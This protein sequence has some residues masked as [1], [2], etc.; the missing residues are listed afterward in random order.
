MPLPSHAFTIHGGCNCR[1]IR[2][3]VN[4][5]PFSERT[6]HPASGKDELRYPFSAIC[7]CN[8]CRRATGALITYGYCCA[9]SS[10]SFCLASASTSNSNHETWTPAA[11]LFPPSTQ[12]R[13]DTYLQFYASSEDRTRCFCARCGTMIGY[14]VHPMPE[15]WPE[16]LDLWTG[17]VDREDLEREWLVPGRHVQLDF[18]IPWVGKM[19]VEG[20]DGLGGLPKHKRGTGHDLDVV[21]TAK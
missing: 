18:E 2:Y 4:V 11:A 21:S 3:E 1:A 8:D 7:H 13:S 6:I 14:S 12:D 20:T 17:T 10:V 16:I 19:A 15:G 5:P 9:M